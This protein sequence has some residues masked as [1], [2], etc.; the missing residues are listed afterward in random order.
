M[1]RLEVHSNIKIESKQEIKQQQEFKHIG[2]GRKRKGLTM[3]AFNYDEQK[4]YAVKL[5]KKTVF[6]VTKRR[7]VAM[8]KAV[9]NPNHPHLYAM[10][11]QNAI[12]KFNKLFLKTKQERR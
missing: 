4:I 5:E 2:A 8:Y 1:D 10:N 11:M 12:R 6:D 3:F 9:I 7:E